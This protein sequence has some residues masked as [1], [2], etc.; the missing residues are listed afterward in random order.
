MSRSS[1]NTKNNSSKN[2]SKNNSS[3]KSQNTRP[4]GINRKNDV[5]PSTTAAITTLPQTTRPQMK[6]K[7]QQ[8]SN[9]DSVGDTVNTGYTDIID[10]LSVSPTAKDQTAITW[11]DQVSDFIIMFLKYLFLVVILTMNFLGLSVSLNCNADQEMGMRIGSAV[12][13]FFFGFVYLLINYYTYKVLSQGK[14][15][16]MNTEKLFPFKM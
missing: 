14:I 1:N 7:P 6:T 16:K 3:K 13:A 10:I 11:Q 12:F 9:F 4:T 2:N 5:K 8:R 15:C